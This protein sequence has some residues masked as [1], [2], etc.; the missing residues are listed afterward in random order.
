MKF[1]VNKRTVLFKVK[2]IIQNPTRIYFTGTQEFIAPNYS[3][4]G[5]AYVSPRALKAQLNYQVPYNI[6]EIKGNHHNM[7]KATET[8]LEKD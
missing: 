1:S 8:I 6:V 2:G 5:Y 3:N 4:Y 7:R